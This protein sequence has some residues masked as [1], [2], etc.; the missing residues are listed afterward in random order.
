MQVMGI[1]VVLGLAVVMICIGFW[2][3]KKNKTTDDYYVG[4][5]SLGPVVTICTQCATFVGGGMTLGWIGMGYSRG[6]GAAWYGAPQAL[7]FFFLAAFLVKH[8]RHSGKFISVP[9]WFDGMYKNKFLSIVSALVCLIVPVT[10]VTGQTTAAARMLEGIGI[11]FVVGVFLMGGVVILYST[12]GGYLAVVYTDTVQ[13]ILLFVLFLCTTPF[14][15]YYAGGVSATFANNPDFMSQM[16]HVEGMPGYTIFLWLIAG[17]VAGMGLQSSY[18]RIYSAK[19]DGIAK[20]GLV[21]TGIATIFFALFTAVVGMAVRSLADTPTDLA[22]DGVWPWFLNN[23]M[24][25]Y[26]AIIYTALIMMATMSTADSML[27]SISLTITHD[28][29][30]KFIN[31][32]ADDKKVLKVGIIVSGVFGLIA[33]YWATAGA[34]MIK[35]FGLSYT[36]GAGPMAAGII[37]AALFR[38]RINGTFLALGMLAGALTGYITTLVPGLSSIPAG[39]TVFSFSASLIVG[40]IGLAYKKESDPAEKELETEAAK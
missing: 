15:I 1:A 29:Y 18:Q 4:G 25:G 19:T 3:S 28:L 12:I 38:T 5:R 33:L 31:P 11:P 21:A 32:Q 27:N 24:P 26:V 40:L 17:L 30:S 36:L 14:A 37:L 20:M 13:W 23:H 22:Q 35:L 9:D 16:F 2:A 34:W 6:I 7:G 39:G 10:W 8:M